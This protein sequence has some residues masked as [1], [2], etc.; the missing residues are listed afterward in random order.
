MGFTREQ[1][2]ILEAA[3]AQGALDVNYGDK[4]VTYRSLNEMM[5]TRDLM[6]KELGL[7]GNSTSG[8]SNRRFA[9]HGKGLK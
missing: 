7:S 5:R 1:L 4:R 2:D 8:N 3:I 9:V 6:K